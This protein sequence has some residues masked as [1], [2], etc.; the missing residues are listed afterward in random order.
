VAV[1]SL[2]ASEGGAVSL[3]IQIAV[4]V[5]G[6]LNAVLLGVLLITASSRSRRDLELSAELRAA[7]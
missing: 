5:V 1:A 4:L 7:R 2:I 6:L 3:G